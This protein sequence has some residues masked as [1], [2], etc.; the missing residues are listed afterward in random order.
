MKPRTD[1]SILQ[2]ASDSSTL[3]LPFSLYL[4][5]RAV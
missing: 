3:A 4:A 5:I 2:A 1:G